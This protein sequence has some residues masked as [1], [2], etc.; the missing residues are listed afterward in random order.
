MAKTY[1]FTKARQNLKSV[2]DQAEKDGEVRI[3]RRGGKS[4]VVRVETSNRSPLDIPGV[5]TDITLDEIIESVREGREYD[6]RERRD[7]YPSE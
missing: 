6:I 4:F 7:T 1:T 5:E 2:L 3:T